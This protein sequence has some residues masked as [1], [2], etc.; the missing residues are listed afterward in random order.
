[1]GIGDLGVMVSPDDLG[2]ANPGKICVKRI[3]GAEFRLAAGWSVVPG[4]G[5]ADNS[6]G[7]VREYR[8]VQALRTTRTNA[9]VNVAAPK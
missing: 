8:M 3:L 6:P 1:M 9:S 7:V 2:V 5:I 4:S